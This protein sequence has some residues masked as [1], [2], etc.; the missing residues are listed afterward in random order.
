MLL[1][2][3]LTRRPQKKM[4][5]LPTMVLNYNIRPRTLAKRRW[6]GRFILAL[7]SGLMERSLEA[8]LEQDTE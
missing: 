5:A 7:N 2:D 3:L 6:K 1:R 4:Q 8:H